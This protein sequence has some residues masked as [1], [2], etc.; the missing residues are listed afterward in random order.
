M[1]IRGA[2][3][4]LAVLLSAVPGG[5]VAAQNFPARLVRIVSSAPGNLSD[6]M[7]RIVAQELTKAWGQPVIVENQIGRAHV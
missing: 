4:V 1:K 7:A 6:I 3:V 2:G 5:F